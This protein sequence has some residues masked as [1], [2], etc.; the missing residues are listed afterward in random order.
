MKQYP[1][2]HGY[3]I[4][5]YIILYHIILLPFLLL[6]YSEKNLN[7]LKIK[8]RQMC[9]KKVFLNPLTYGVEYS[10][11]PLENLKILDVRDLFVADAPIKNKKFSF[12][13]S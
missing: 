3:I 2:N 5:Y 6:I 4:K 11:P 8:S 1:L 10:P 7:S 13:P 12:T 9:S